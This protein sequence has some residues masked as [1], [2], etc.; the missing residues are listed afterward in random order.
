ML[1]WRTDA[2]D[3]GQGDHA[4]SQILA[5]ANYLFKSMRM[6]CAFGYDTESHEIRDGF[7]SRKNG[8]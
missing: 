4:F 2:L 6:A 8:L 1:N 3:A 7:G 5:S